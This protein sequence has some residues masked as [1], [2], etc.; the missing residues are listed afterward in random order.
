MPAFVILQVQLVAGL[1]SPLGHGKLE[2]SLEH[3][4]LGSLRHLHGPELHLSP[5]LETFGIRTVRGHHGMKCGSSWTE[6]F[7]F[8]LVSYPVK[9]R[10]VVRYPFFT[11]RGWAPWIPTY[12]S[13]DST[14]DGRCPRLRT[15]EVGR[16]QSLR[17]PSLAWRTD[18]WGRWRWMGRSDHNWRCWS[19]RILTGHTR[20]KIHLVSQ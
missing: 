13:C 1:L 8:C 18:T 12:S 3:E 10:L 19:H 20:I 16:W 14:E 17:W 4:G 9:V 11:F 15:S 2:R 6:S 5:V 7:F